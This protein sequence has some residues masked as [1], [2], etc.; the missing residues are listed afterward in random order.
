MRKFPFFLGLGF[1]LVFCSAF[2]GRAEETIPYTTQKEAF[3][4]QRAALQ[5]DYAALATAADKQAFRQRLGRKIVDHLHEELVPYWYGTQWD[6]N[7]TTQVPK[8][9]AIACGYFVST[10][11]RDAGFKVERVRMAQQAS[12]Y[13]VRTVAPKG[14]RWDY[15]GISTAAF[16]E[17]VRG[18]GEGLY[19]VGLDFHTG[20][21][22]CEGDDVWFIHSSYGEPFGVVKEVAE[23]SAV[24]A[25]SNRFVLGKVN[26]DELVGKWLR[27][28]K[29]AT[30]MP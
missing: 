28:E 5:R 9:G 24:L 2:I 7:G 18:L 21:V 15:G 11:L 14:Q 25:Q 3:T 20:F 4:A 8:E 27:G 30:V 26:N 17:K 19:V 29:I 16:A 1:L 13:I 6:F 23:E 12:L 10:L 22:L